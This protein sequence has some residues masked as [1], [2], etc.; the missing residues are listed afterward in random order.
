MNINTLVRFS[1]WEPPAQAAKPRENLWYRV[2]SF[3]VLIEL[4]SILLCSHGWHMKTGHIHVTW[5]IWCGL[6][7]MYKA[8]A[9]IKL[10]LILC[11]H[12]A[13]LMPILCV[14]VNTAANLSLG[15]HI[16][17]NK[18]YLQIEKFKVTVK[19]DANLTWE[20]HPKNF[21]CWKILVQNAVPG[22]SGMPA[23]GA[24]CSSTQSPGINWNTVVTISRIPLAKPAK[25]SL[26]PINL[27]FSA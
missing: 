21:V 24:L 4:K 13:Y 18:C 5:Q 22:L 12:A 19:Q 14:M 16:L 15:L 20:Y 25:T 6:N 26:L 1:G 8:S 2:G 23:S 27:A 10:I 3:T 11:C 9:V 17:C 7:Y